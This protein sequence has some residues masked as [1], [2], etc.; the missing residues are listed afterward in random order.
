MNLRV[1]MFDEVTSTNNLIKDAIAAGE[2][3]GLVARALRQNAGYGRQGRGWKSPDGGLYC[4]WL[5]RPEVEPTHLATLSLVVGLAVQEA[6]QA[7][8]AELGGVFGNQTIA[9]KW[10]ND[11]VVMAEGEPGFKKLCGISTEAVHGAICVGIGINVCAPADVEEGASAEQAAGESA[12]DRHEGIKPAIPDQTPSESKSTQTNERIPFYLSA[13]CR[14]DGS[15]IFSGMT[16]S[17][18]LDTVFESLATRLIPTYERWSQEGFA[19]FVK[20]FNDHNM[21]DGKH[22]KLT[23]NNGDSLYEGFVEGANPDGTLCLQLLDGSEIAASSG[24][25]HVLMQ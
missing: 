9:V 15:S 6:C 1:Q 21:L 16:Q 7:C 24:E 19:P 25:V 4:S 14:A 12:C 22:I 11:V 17:Q 3:E 18:A 23:N 2:S 20:T 13:F 5:F 8:V 10:P